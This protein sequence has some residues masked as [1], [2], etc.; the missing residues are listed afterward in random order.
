MKRMKIGHIFI[1]IW[2]GEN[3]I[4]P[5]NLP[6]FTLPYTSCTPSEIS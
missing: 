2:E 6:S 1:F 4:E 3:G 5:M